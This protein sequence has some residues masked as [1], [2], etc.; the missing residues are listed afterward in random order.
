MC[1]CDIDHHANCFKFDF[2]RVHIH[3]CLGYNY[4]KNNC[5][6]Y[7]DDDVCPSMSFCFC[8]ECYYGSRCQFTSNGFGLS[9]DAILG[10]SIWIRVVHSF[11]CVMYIQVEHKPR[12]HFKNTRRKSKRGA[13]QSNEKIRFRCR[14]APRL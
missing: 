13:F 1:L 2:H 11:F 9:L 6:Y 7:H 8:T 12:D 5:K 10:Y 3:S 14:G 4:C